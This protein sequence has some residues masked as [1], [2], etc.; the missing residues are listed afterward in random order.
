MLL[1]EVR[2]VINQQN[3]RLTLFASGE[4]VEDES[5]TFEGRKVSKTE[6]NEISKA[7]FDT[8][9]DFMYYAVHGE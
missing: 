4:P 1:T 8:L 3:A 6:A 5:W 2:I 7:M 9:Y